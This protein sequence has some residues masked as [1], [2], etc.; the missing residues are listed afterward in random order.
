M[1]SK[2][3]QTSLQH[4]IV[5]K[6]AEI[7]IDASSSFTDR[8]IYFSCYLLVNNLVISR[9]TY[10]KQGKFKFNI[11]KTGN[12][13]VKLYIYDKESEL[14]THKYV[15]LKTVLCESQ[16]YK[17]NVANFI[18]DSNSECGKLLF[19]SNILSFSN[20]SDVELQGLSGF[21][22][23]DPYNNRTW[24]WKLQQ[25]QH[26]INLINYAEKQDNK[27]EIIKLAIM[28]FKEWCY[29]KD[30]ETSKNDQML[31]Q[32]HV[33]ALRLHN[34][35]FM[36][37]YLINYKIILESDEL[38]DL[39]LKNIKEH[40]D[41]LSED[42]FYSKH[43]N[44]GFDQS[45]FLYQAA[46]ELE[47][48]LDL[49]EIISLAESRVLDEIN[50]AF[51]DDGGHKENSPAYL[52]FGIKQCLSFIK[53]SES[54]QEESHCIDDI[55]KIIDKATKA[56]TY[57]V[58]PNGYLPLIGDT[59]IFKVND[60]FREYKPESYQNFKYSIT[61]GKA[62]KKPLLNS[63]V[64]EDTGYAIYRS[65]WEKDNFNDSIYL[66]CKAS[67]KSNY[68]RH[69]DDLSITLYA[70]GE[71]WFVDGSIYKYDEKDKHRRYIRS[72][73]SHNLLSPVG[74]IANRKHDARHQ[75]Y[76]INNE[77]SQKN[78]FDISATTSMYTGYKVR[79]CL[80]VNSSEEI[81]IVDECQSLSKDNFNIV[82]RFFICPNKEITINGNE[83]YIKGKKKNLI[84]SFESVNPLIIRQKS[85]SQAQVYGW[86]SNSLNNLYQAQVI[87]I[88]SEFSDSQFEVKSNLRFE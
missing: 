34:F 86:L 36:F 61:Q 9:Q 18:T 35:T 85:Y 64:L 57:F 27:N 46:L 58:K 22:E 88:E 74:A 79:R 48:I 2:V 4:K 6:G 19:D 83:V 80:R 49:R 31:W 81:Y 71:D 60:I 38:Y 16:Y 33:T 29:Y 39:F 14:R 10:Q 75:V 44:H 8:N 66:T 23:L 84:M 72:H 41:I 37:S 30:A 70:Y 87:E 15:D 62:G 51:C 59:S 28:L 54:Y 53:I 42:S 5:V 43:T 52:N 32:D 1:D 63:L 7:S 73:M 21:Y 13:A 82:L 56:L 25:M 67:Y 11:C 76:L 3:L 12:Y 47:Y 69:D 17:S 78:I 40:I 77:L 26:L 55:K 65:G 68:H 45:I 20:F 24:R 50:F